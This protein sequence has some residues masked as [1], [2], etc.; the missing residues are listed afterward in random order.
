MY[1]VIN[2]SVNTR[3]SPSLVFI[4]MYFHPLTL[5]TSKTLKISSCQYNQSYTIKTAL[6]S[7]RTYGKK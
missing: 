3:G 7:D 1:Y 6:T 5:L 2:F 4:A